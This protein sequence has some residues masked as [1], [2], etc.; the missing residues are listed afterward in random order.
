MTADISQLLNTQLTIKH[1]S[2]YLLTYLPSLLAASIC[3]CIHLFIFHYSLLQ[4]KHSKCT[5]STTGQK[6]KIPLVTRKQDMALSQG[7]SKPTY[8]NQAH[9]SFVHTPLQ[10]L[11]Y[12]PL[13]C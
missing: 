2:S 3:L 4:M 1:L 7:S 11:L 9:L 5:I 13:F 8:Q 12:I 6:T 10:P